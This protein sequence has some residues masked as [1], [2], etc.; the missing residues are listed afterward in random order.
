MS[1]WSGPGQ[2]DNLNKCQLADHLNTNPPGV[3][4]NSK[5][6]N[7]TPR[8][9]TWRAVHVAVLL[10]K[11]GAALRRSPEDEP[12]DVQPSYVREAVL[13][14]SLAEADKRLDELG[15]L[16][17]KAAEAKRKQRERA[18][19]KRDNRKERERA[20]AKA[21]TAARRKVVAAAVEAATE[22]VAQRTIKVLDTKYKADEEERAKEVSTARARA[23]PGTRRREQSQ[24]LSQG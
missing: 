5:K 6:P 13:K 3:S 16:L 18:Q 24:A 10:L 8:W 15:T 20:K 14:D 7:G 1:L 9:R 19:E 11:H 12:M 4:A 22:R 17:R 21:E 23:T 2:F